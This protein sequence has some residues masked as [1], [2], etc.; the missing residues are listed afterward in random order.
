MS[1]DTYNGWTNW[2]TWSAAL[3]LGNDEPAYRAACRAAERMD[4]R[5]QNWS[6]THPMRVVYEEW[7]PYMP[8][9]DGEQQGD[10]AD[11][12]MVDWNAVAASFGMVE[13]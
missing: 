11:L 7:V 12:G 8:T 13:A 2:D 10:G 6:H 5:G 4:G 1:D 9:E 3:W